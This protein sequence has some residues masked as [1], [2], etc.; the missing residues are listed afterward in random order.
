MPR[1]NNNDFLPFYKASVSWV[2]FIVNAE[3][4]HKYIRLSIKDL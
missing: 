3:I 1:G 2:T 4:P